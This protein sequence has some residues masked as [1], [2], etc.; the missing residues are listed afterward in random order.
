MNTG[1]C[2]N[3]RLG[4]IGANLFFPG[5]GS[6]LLGMTR[7]FALGL[8]LLNDYRNKRILKRQEENSMHIAKGLVLPTYFTCIYTLIAFDFVSGFFAIILSVANMTP[9]KRLRIN[10]WILPIESGAFHCL[11]EGL[12]IF[13]LSYGGGQRAF[14]HALRYGVLWGTVT[15]VFEA[16][17]IRFL[18]HIEESDDLGINRNAGFSL[19]VTYYSLLTIFYG[20]LSFAPL[21]VVY[22]RPATFTYA[23]FN[24]CLSIFWIIAICFVRYYSI[25]T[26]CGFSIVGLILIGIFQPLCVWWTLRS[27]SQYWQGKCNII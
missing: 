6:F 22:R 13:L 21:S 7:I 18:F 24:M 20:T 19:F 3:S 11:F 1:V 25:S 17:E 4:D 12:A 15:A 27:D 8:L 2:S 23:L 14:Q 5:T 9:M 16:L 26:L 10:A